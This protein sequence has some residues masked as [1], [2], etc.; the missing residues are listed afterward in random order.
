[1]R[2]TRY[3]DNA[4]RCLTYLALNP[5]TPE[6]VG[7]IARRMR[8]SEDHLFKVVGQLAQLGYVETLRGRA[9][10]V[11]LARAPGEIR[12]GTIVRQMEDNMA[13][14]ECFDPEA[15]TCPIAPACVLAV[16]LDRALKAFLGVLDEVTVADLVRQP[17]R[18]ARLLPV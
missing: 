9:G 15:N 17:K 3:T 5:D 16:T 12:V 2:L 13:L 10:G 6:T 14:V 18:L 1:M 11:V 7:E 8:I 4:L